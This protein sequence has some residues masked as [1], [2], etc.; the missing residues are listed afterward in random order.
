MKKVFVIDLRNHGDSGRSPDFSY[1]AMY[2]DLENFIRKLNEPII[3]IGHSL[4]S[5]VTMGFAMKEPNLIEKLISVDISPRDYPMN[6]EMKILSALVR[7]RESLQFVPSDYSLN[8]AKSFLEEDLKKNNVVPAVRKIFLSTLM[9]QDNGLQF[10]TNLEAVE[11]YIC[12]KKTIR[13]SYPLPGYYKGSA[14]IVHGGMSDYVSPGDYED[15]KIV[16]PKAS[17]VCINDSDHWIH[18]E[19]PDD[20]SNAILSFL[21]SK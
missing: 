4:G 14:L 7:V 20:L 17:F 5:T 21:C 16:F 2:R 13:K 8:E 9:K 15:V 18:V 1:S 3:L 10:K 19:K 12:N 6:T 11:E